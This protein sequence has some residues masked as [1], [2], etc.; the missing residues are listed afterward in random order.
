MAKE[1]IQPPNLA[2]PMAETTVGRRLWA[3]RIKAGFES[4]SAFTK[5]LAARAR[6]PLAYTT[7]NAWDKG[8]NIGNDYLFEY[9]AMVGVT[10]DEVTKGV[11]VS[12]QAK[13]LLTAEPRVERLQPVSEDMAERE[14]WTAAAMRFAGFVEGT[15]RWQ[16]AWQRI[17]RARGRYGIT[18][19]IV[20]ELLEALLLGE[21]GISAEEAEARAAMELKRKELEARGIAVQPKPEEAAKKKTDRDPQS[22]TRMKDPSIG[23]EKPKAKR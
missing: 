22:G 20:A 5:Q 1:Q 18:P 23:Q 14:R 19:E 10:V 4:R 2:N 21:R 17:M 7:V 11:A 3:L 13:E 6:K 12:D 9:C 16:H 15:A 8:G